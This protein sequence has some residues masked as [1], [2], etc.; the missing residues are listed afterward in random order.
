MRRPLALL[1]LPVLAGCVAYPKVYWRTLKGQARVDD[2]KPITIKA[3]IVKQCDT[4][5]GEHETEGRQR[6]TQTDSQGRYKLGVHGMVWHFKS[7]LTP[8]TCT[9]RIQMYVCRDYCRVA[10]EVDIE[11]LGK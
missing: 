9:S 5:E 6:E 3:A 2:G 8:K 1:L 10:D 7:F 11:V 4:M